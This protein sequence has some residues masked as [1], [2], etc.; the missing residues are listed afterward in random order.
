[1]TLIEVGGSKDIKMACYQIDPYL[2]DPEKTTVYLYKDPGREVIDIGDFESFDH[3]EIKK[4]ADLPQETKEYY[5]ETYKKGERPLIFHKVVH[6][7]YK[8]SIKC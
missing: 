1:M 3:E 4:Y 2:L 7:L 6:I 8:G 5:K